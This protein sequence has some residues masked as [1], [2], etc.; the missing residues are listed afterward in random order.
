MGVSNE[1]C[2]FLTSKFQIQM[3]LPK[4]EIH[5]NLK[6]EGSKIQIFISHSHITSSSTS[7]TWHNKPHSQTPNEREMVRVAVKHPNEQNPG[8][9]FVDCPAAPAEYPQTVSRM[10]HRDP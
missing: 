1:N 6:F 10:D 4:K 7:L 9:T 2:Y 8:A 3:K 5:L